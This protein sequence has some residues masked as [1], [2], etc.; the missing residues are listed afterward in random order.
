MVEQRRPL[1]NVTMPLNTPADSPRPASGARAAPPV[2]ATA[3][4]LNDQSEPLRDRGIS[5]DISLG[6]ERRIG[7]TR[8]AM[9]G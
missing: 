5:S 2:G 1:D 7:S 3:Q 4:H 6:R 9:I 8:S